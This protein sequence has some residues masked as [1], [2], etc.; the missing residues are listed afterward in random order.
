M[1]QITKLVS[2]L[3]MDESTFVR[4]SAGLDAFESNI[5]TINAIGTAV[6]DAM[7]FRIVCI[8]ITDYILYFENKEIWTKHMCRYV[9]CT[10]KCLTECH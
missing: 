8:S 2:I 9:L 5:F 3:K 6:A 1:V 4:Y 7:A 10:C